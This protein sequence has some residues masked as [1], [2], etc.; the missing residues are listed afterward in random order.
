MKSFSSETIFKKT[1]SISL[2]SGMVQSA[3]RILD[4]CLDSV[5]SSLANTCLNLII[6]FVYNMVSLSM[7]SY[8]VLSLKVVLCSAL[9][10]SS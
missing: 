4:I 9:F 8:V 3:K 2:V 1:I 6:S 5:F 10:K 7:M